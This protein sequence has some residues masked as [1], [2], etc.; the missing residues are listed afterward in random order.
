MVEDVEALGVGRHH[1]VL[2]AVMDHLDEVTGA[3]R[4]AVQ[5]A[6]LGLVRLAFAAGSARGRGDSRR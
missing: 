2:D 6:L 3:H 1:A 4:S 5:I